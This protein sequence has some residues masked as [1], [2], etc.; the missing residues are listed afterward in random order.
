MR[1]PGRWA[2][3]L[4]AVLSSV[5]TVVRAALPDGF[6][7][8]EVKWLQLETDHFVVVFC[9]GLEDTA[10]LAGRIL[11]EAHGP[12]CDMLG[13]R[14][15]AKT[16]LVI[17][18]FDDV[19]FNNFARRMEHVIYISNPVMNQARVDTESW[20]RHLLRHEYAHVING[21]ALRRFG[22][23]VGPV[24]EWTGMELQP[25]WFTEGLAE[26]V[27]SGGGEH[28]DEVSFVLQ[29]A[30]QD[31]LLYG[32]K[33]DIAD[34]RFDVMETAV[35][36]RQGYSMCLFMAQRYG[37][38]IMKRILSAYAHAPQFDIAFKLATGEHIEHFYKEWLKTITAKAAQLPTEEAL[39]AV[40][41]TWDL[42]IE[43]ALGA[44]M[45]PDGRRLAVYGIWDWE[46]P[47]PALYLCDADGRGFRRIASNLDIYYSWKMTWTPD[48]R[49]L[50]YI[51]RIKTGNGAI[52]NAL[53]AYDVEQ[54]KG[55]K[56]NTGD[57]RI[58]D[59]D[60]SPDGTT[61]AFTTYLGERAL[62]ATMRLPDGGDLKYV[63]HALPQNCFS[64]SWS[65][66]GQR[67]A[68]S[69][70]DTD[71]VDIATIK[72]DGSDYRRLATDL[73]PDQY[74]AWSPDGKSIAF[75][76]YRPVEG[77]A[78]ERKGEGAA[79]SGEAEGLA[80]ARTNIYTIPTDGGEMTQVTAATTGGVYYPCWTPDGDLVVSLYRVRTAEVRRVKVAAA[81]AM[82]AAPAASAETTASAPGLTQAEPSGVRL[83]ALP[84]AGGALRPAAEPRSAD[85]AAPTTAPL[86]S[87]ITPA[88]PVAR[89]QLGPQGPAVAVA[90]AAVDSAEPGD[91]PRV[92]PYNSWTHIQP[93]IT[94][95]YSGDDGLGD[96]LGVRTR[97]TDPLNQHNF[98]FEVEY[99]LESD[100]VAYQLQYYND[101]TPVRAGINVFRRVPPFRAERGVLVAEVSE[102]AEI[103]GELP[104]AIGSN[105][106]ANDKIR[107]G[108]E[109]ADHQ[110]FKTAGGVLR[111]RPRP[112]IIAG[113][114]IGYRRQ[115][116]L[117]GIGDQEI[118]AK[119]TRADTRFGST[120]NFV[121][122]N[123]TWAAHFFGPDPR[124]Q[125]GVGAGLNYF[126]GE[127]FTRA[128]IQSWILSAEAR[129]DWR[130]CDEVLS[131]HTWPYLHI[132]PVSFTT[133]YRM[134][135]LIN[136]IPGG[137]DLRDRFQIGL[138]NRGYL[139]RHF[140]YELNLVENLYI[141][142]GD[143]TEFLGTIR[144]EFRDLP[145]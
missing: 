121:S 138:T 141:G 96:T 111:P 6:P 112:A 104:I 103:L 38:D 122:M 34:L 117:P 95:P 127:D 68:F 29:A 21:W 65:P 93:Y 126:D 91:E 5:P 43:A 84:D 140:V 64:P 115:Q 105:P 135:E 106:Y 101:Q 128:E 23:A 92:R 62:I 69:V 89:P 51:G 88:P 46:Q 47:I 123:A 53:F 71:G 98:N 67:L 99:G 77:L 124:R 49:Y 144:F 66:D 37:D 79:V 75:V 72:P 143:R 114:S 41:Q 55:W 130:L 94:R 132:G 16:T 50:L 17:A 59:P 44:R 137:A 78:V 1:G 3:V 110:P 133:S 74:P 14:P 60:L 129:Y 109:Y 57:V 26:Y 70:A 87:A 131:R 63:T 116:L 15:E 36:Y 142:S 76:S 120:L 61:L 113:P 22:V 58:F 102:G 100:K 48:S 40:S 86:R 27:A 33:L 97:M 134:R 7:H 30:Q 56:V 20:L 85:S 28:A 83:A 145:F 10:R 107:F 73:W 136:G 2:A 108:Y 119:L 52:R 24:I 9:D 11:E 32:G 18:D 31:L 12:M 80:S 4:V 118:N 45:S 19:G 82:A 54:G 81:A 139:T 35:L 39:D 42:P 25:Q 13:A 90:A 8:P 125:F